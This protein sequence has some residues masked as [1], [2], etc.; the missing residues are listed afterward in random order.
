MSDWQLDMP[1]ELMIDI[2]VIEVGLCF[3]PV[4]AVGMPFQ[5]TDDFRSLMYC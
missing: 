1:H 4:I 3:S 5:I 2:I